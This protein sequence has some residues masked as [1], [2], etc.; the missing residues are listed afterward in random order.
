MKKHLKLSVA[1]AAALLVF[2][3]FFAT[4]ALAQGAARADEW[5]YTVAKGDT[6]IALINRL[7]KPDTDWRKLQ[8]M[9]KLGDA[10][11]LAPGTV[12]R[13]PVGWLR[14]DAAVATVTVAQGSI[15]VRRGLT[16]LGATAAGAE[17]LPGDRIETGPQ[18]T[19]ALRF[20]DG[21]RMVIA[22]D[23]KV[24]LEKLL[25]YGKT[26]ITETHLKIEE[27]SVD[28]R[29]TPMPAT[30]SKY[31][32][33]T[34]VFNLGVRGTDFR[35]RFDPK[36]QTA[37]N[38]VLEGKVATQ[39]KASEV[40]VGAGF[41][42]LALINTEPKPPIKL[43]DAPLLRGITKNIDQVPLN[44]TWDPETGAAG[45]RAKVFQDQTLE[46]QLLEGV[47][48]KPVARWADLPDGAYVLQVRSIDADGLEGAG[49]TRDFVLKA[50]PVA[51]FTSQPANTT[52]VY[53]DD[54][55]FKWS[56]SQAA[57]KYR[58]QVAATA[59]FK[60]PLVDRKDV[61]GAQATVPLGPGNY[62]WRI[63]AIAKGNDQGPFGDVSAFVQRKIP[64]GPGTL[65]AP[66]VSDSEMV[67]NWKA[68]EPGHSFKYQVSRDPGFSTQMLEK[69]TAEPVARFYKPYSGTYYMRIKAIDADGFEG[70]FGAAQ[71]FVV[72]EPEPTSWKPWPLLLLML[73]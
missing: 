64:E 68:N 27:G 48:S 1:S 55:T 32:V 12:V 4:G 42:T 58:L 29:V 10:Q 3:V 38:E 23:S 62:F 61:A 43:L 31:V 34:P 16:L 70:P 59:D 8:Q 53:G 57:E 37:F 67:F 9:N 26:G 6:L 52:K 40:L 7:M 13:I 46:R 47:F 11:R 21:S 20:V 17:L 18:S 28:S 22:P 14:G 36:T 63:A 49:S 39:G 41:G 65:D 30:A 45:Y 54:V 72:E 56:E 60:A 71:K 33:T 73:L 25:V 5:N 51:P 15:L 66:A 69:A 50:R 44:L 19:L 24:L 35:A 2:S